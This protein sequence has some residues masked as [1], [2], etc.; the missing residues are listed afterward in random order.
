[1][2]WSAI[3]A[4][5]MLLSGCASRTATAPAPAPEPSGY[6]EP[7]AALRYA[8]ERR[9]PLDNA[10]NIAE[11][12]ARAAAQRDAMER[13]SSRIGRSLPFAIKPNNVLDAWT[14]LGPGN[15]G[16]RT[17]VI[18]YHPTVKA[19][20]FAAG[21]SGGIWRSDDD[22]GSWRPIAEGLSNLAI[23][24]LVIDPKAPDV[25]YA[26]TGEGYL[27][28]DIRGTG[29][30]LRGSGIFVTRNGGSTWQRLPSTTSN[31]FLWVN[32]L[33][34]GVGDSRRL[35]AATRTGVWRSLDAGSSWVQLLSVTV[36]G[37]C[38]D[39]AI[40]PD[41]ASDTLFASC[42][43]YEPAAVYRFV[44]ASG[45]TAPETVLQQPSMGRTS[46]AIAPSAPDIVYALA[47]SNDVGPNG[48]YQ[49]GLLAVY[50]SDRGGAAGSW[51]PR[52][53]NTDA[54]YINTLLLTNVAPATVEQCFAG[55]SRNGF[56]NMGWYN[57]VIAVDPKDPER[58]WASGVNWFRSDDGGKNWGLAAVQLGPPESATG[59]HVDQHTITFHPDY[60]GDANQIV[61]VG[62]D[63]GIARTRNARAR[64]STGNRAS[65]DA[66]TA[67]GISW[68]S[69][70]RGYGVTQFYHGLPFPDGT[71]YMGG[72]QDNSTLIGGDDTGADGWRSVIGGDGGYVAINPQNPQILYGEFQWASMGKSID[73][74][75]TF[76]TVTNGL[77]PVQ[78]SLYDGDANYLFVAPLVMD[79]E[80][81]SRLWVG[82]DYLYRTTNAAV[83]WSKASALL[84]DGGRA[85][86]IAISPTDSNR[87]IVGTNK[88]DI[89]STRAALAAVATTVWETIRPR[90]GWITSVAFD[91]RNVTTLYTTYGNFG[92]R[93]VY[94]STNDGASW[95]SSDG[96]G[97]PA[98]SIPD[99]PV[100]S[101]VIDP[102]DSSRLYLGTD[103]GVF[104]SLDAGATWQVEETGFGPAVTEWL[105]LIRDTSGR[106]RLFAFTHGR[107]VWRV[108][109]R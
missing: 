30:P 62:N 39:L 33:E 103:I 82:G 18:K 95:S 105:S 88:G 51:S 9:A 48:N 67:L 21:V 17:R 44:N 99:V 43:T 80:N 6:D 25:M 63:G 7:G 74:G 71:H 94:R 61:L 93:H 106:K 100:H 50:R 52:V 59:T 54:S 3:V 24:S 89:V 19:T 2:R 27:R 60:D 78:S 90:D 96:P 98:R 77:D 109:L 13:F 42:G 68:S 46:I 70:N 1:M 26:G 34:L 64:T 58:V 23:N 31:D 32:D 75:H 84:P 57:N 36:R 69:L 83:S 15:I 85:S 41:T 10:I 104:V 11:S 22:G 86:T 53:T 91:P 4:T 12:Y 35:Y 81:P 101:I 28:E 102:D 55:Q 8:Q 16:G 29:L 37:G 76:G 73:G 5:V 47:A 40:R 66:T 97:D 56:T 79:P 92:G 14:Y 38:L 87:I 20:I 108:D 49:Q 45:S 107:G 65:C 72:A